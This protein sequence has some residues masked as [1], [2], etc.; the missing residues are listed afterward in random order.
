[1]IRRPAA[2]AAFRQARTETAG[3]TTMMLRR[4]A[5]APARLLAERPSP[6]IGA[7]IGWSSAPDRLRLGRLSLP[8]RRSVRPGAAA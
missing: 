3:R 5:G 6:S 1:M 4:A 2:G 8:V 7:Q